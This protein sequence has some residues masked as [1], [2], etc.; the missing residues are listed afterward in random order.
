M[1][2]RVVFLMYFRASRE[3]CIVL[4]TLL[5]ERFLSDDERGKFFSSF[6]PSCRWTSSL[7]TYGI[8]NR[9]WA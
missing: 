6:S 8:V 9:P 1:C 7:R 4:P 5:Y 2:V 3:K